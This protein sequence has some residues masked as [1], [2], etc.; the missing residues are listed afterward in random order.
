MF[1]I[2]IYTGAGLYFLVMATGLIH[3]EYMSTMGRNRRMGL[4]VMGAGFVIL[5]IS[6]IFY[7]YLQSDS[8]PVK[9]ERIKEEYRHYR[10]PE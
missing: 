4:I 9:S 1:F 8:S 6:Q 3:R 5:G 10:A 2:I 7:Y